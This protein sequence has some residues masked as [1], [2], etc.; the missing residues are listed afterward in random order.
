MFVFI[1]QTALLLAIALVIGMVIGWALR[2]LFGAKSVSGET[3]TSRA[4][5]SGAPETEKVV[6]SGLHVPQPPMPEGKKAELVGIASRGTAQSASKPKA[7]KSATG[8]KPA[9]KSTGE[10]APDAAVDDKQEAAAILAALP[11]AGGR[12]DDLKQVKGIGPQNESRL[13]S[14]GISTFAQL[15][16]LDDA[17]A[18]RLG[19]LLSFPGR[20]ERED[21][22]GQARHLAS[23]EETEFS[24]RVAAG[25]VE[26]S[27][28]T[29][30]QEVT[31]ARPPSLDAPRD[32][33]A[34]PLGAIEGVGPALEKKL[35]RVGIYH[36]DQIATLSKAQQAWL[37]TALGFPGR[38]EREDWAGKAATLDKAGNAKAPPPKR[39]AIKAK[40]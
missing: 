27:K 31:D 36:F 12:E 28:G 6:N 2:H 35:N 23:G 21:W 38:V 13:K 11:D 9:A 22:V 10:K 29:V 7:R 30:A 33:R 20:I 37:G 18:S 4:A 39:G 15:A 14:V 34:D 5:A 17:L 25:K 16:A 19:S 32:G 26:S 8:K 40:K 1:V 3:A 24:R